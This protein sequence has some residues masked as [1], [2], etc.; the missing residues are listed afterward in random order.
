MREF[1]IFKNFLHI[2]KKISS[3][4]FVAYPETEKIYDILSKKYKL[5]RSCFLVTSGS[6]F[7]IR[8]C[9]ELFT[10]KHSKII[11][12]S[13]TFGMV[14]VYAKVFETNQIK[15]GY[16]KNLILDYSKIIK[17]ID[18]SISMIMLANPNSPTGTIID[19]KKIIQI[20]QKAKKNKCYVV[21]DEAYFGFY[22]KTYLNFTKKFNNL[23]ILRTFSKAFGLAGIRAGYI[24]SNKDLIR[25]L[26][27]FRPMYEISS[28]SCLIIEEILKKQNLT[29][30]Y[31][32]STEKGKKYLTNELSKMGFG[33][34]ETFANF[35]LIDFHKKNLGKAIYKNLAKKGILVRRAPNIQATRNC[36]RFTLGPPNYMKK[37][38][39]TLK[40]Y[41]KN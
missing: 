38:V 39:K 20:I 11:S 40:K 3:F 23:I 26:Y 2:I 4:H 6:D 19:T 9:F 31:I 25:K 12:L 34:F 36:L 16:D 24:V 22:K 18:K 8:H 27:S 10:Q 17:S 14:D 15:I 28:L 7:G 21:I 41:S 13:P 35:I 30:S 33:Y 32:S 37:L 29:N 1:Q 5:P